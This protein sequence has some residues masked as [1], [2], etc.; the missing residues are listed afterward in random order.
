MPFRDGDMLVAKITPCFENGKGAVARGLANGVSFG[1][2]ELHVLRP[3]P[4][5]DRRFLFY[6]SISVTFRRLGE[7][8]MYGAG[9]QK[10]VTTAFISDLRTPL[11]PLAEQRP[12][13]CTRGRR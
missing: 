5:L 9:G 1:T 6:V 12:S 7:A 10:R 13:R 2:T 11:P 4:D 8:G 3:K